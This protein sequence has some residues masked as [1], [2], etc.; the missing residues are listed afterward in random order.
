MSISPR[1]SLSQP[2]MST[3]EDYVEEMLHQQQSHSAPPN[4]STFVD[5]GTPTVV[6]MEQRVFLEVVRRFSIVQRH[7][8][9]TR[10]TSCAQQ[11]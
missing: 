9:T 5:D 8:S 7:S 4:I 1:H 11:L 2:T 6:M 10:P 3:S